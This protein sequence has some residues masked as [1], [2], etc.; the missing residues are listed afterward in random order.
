MLIPDKTITKY[1][2]T[3]NQKIIPMGTIWKKDWN[4]YRKGDLFKADKL[5]TK[6][7]GITIHN[8]NDLVNVYDDAEQY[9]RATYPN[10]NMGDARVHFYVDDVSAWQNLELNEIG[11]HASTGAKGKGNI[12]TIAI[13]S[14]MDGSGSKE[15]LGAY[16]NTIKLTATLLYENNWTV[17]DIYTHK[18]WSGKNCPIYILPKWQEF[19]DKV[20]EF[21]DYIKKENGK[22]TTLYYV[23]VGAFSSIENANRCVLDLKS[24]AYK[25][26]F[27]RDNKDSIDTTLITQQIREEFENEYA[28]KLEKLDQEKKEFKNKVI[29]F[30]E[31][32]V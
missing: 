11:W 4:V 32:E 3:I 6:C 25:D 9:T 17:K 18:Y 30:I 8:T 2:L 20:Q 10:Q 24:K 16:E 29:R 14:I 1:G 12:D 5:M 15:D 13:E 28:E 23:Q 26:A 21:L 19:I 22:S 31:S 27:V 7:I